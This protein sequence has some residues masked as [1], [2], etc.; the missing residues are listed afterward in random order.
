[1]QLTKDRI[2][3]GTAKFGYTREVDV[4]ANQ[5]ATFQE[6]NSSNTINLGIK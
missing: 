5:V 2:L 6:D 1:M 3:D 4:A